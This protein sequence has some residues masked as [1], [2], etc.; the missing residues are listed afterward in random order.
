MSRPAPEIAAADGGEAPF[1]RVNPA[2]VAPF[3]LVCDHASRTLPP[4]YGTLGLDAA[5]LWR[6]IAWDIGAADVTRRLAA[7]L[8]APA[9]LSRYSRLLVDCNRAESDPTLVCR[10]SD[11]TVV[12]GNRDIDGTETARRIARYHTPYH[13]AVA[14]EVERLTAAVAPRAPALVD[15]HS[16]TPVMKGF[17]RPWHVG[18]LWNRDPRL[19]QPLMEVLAEDP[20]L[21]VGDNEPYSGQGNVGYTTR[22]HAESAGLPHVLIEVRQDL[23]DTHLGAEAWARRLA[24]ALGRVLAERGPFRREDRAG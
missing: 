22:R 20:T 7:L 18:I 10:I 11:G 9:V 21:V 19:A 23:I 1:E 2:A 17:A 5:E 24:A 14:A 6:H 3:L 16:F 12:P 8:D 13:E 4:A 15:V